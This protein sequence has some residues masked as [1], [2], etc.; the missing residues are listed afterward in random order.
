MFLPFF[1]LFLSAHS[2]ALTVTAVKQTLILSNR[3]IAEKEEA[4]STVSTDCEKKH[5]R[6]ILLACAMAR[7][8]DER[9]DVLRDIDE[10]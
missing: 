3:S 8:Q 10:L 2:R 5:S 1:S 7:E 4:S 6:S 9:L